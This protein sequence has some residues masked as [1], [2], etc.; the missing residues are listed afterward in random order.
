MHR[1]NTQLETNTAH[2]V[3]IR[4]AM[5]YIKSALRFSYSAVAKTNTHF[6]QL[7]KR[8]AERERVH[9]KRAPHLSNPSWPAVGGQHC[10]KA[11]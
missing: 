10:Q 6:T 1:H 4:L 9:I 3:V 2:F 11:N 7:L 8:N 5:V